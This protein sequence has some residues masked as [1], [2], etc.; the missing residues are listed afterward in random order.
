MPLIIRALVPRA[1]GLA[2]SAIDLHA[3]DPHTCLEASLLL[4][5]AELRG[6]SGFSGVPAG[7][8]PELAKHLVRRV[9]AAVGVRRDGPRFVLYLLG[10]EGR[11]RD[12]EGRRAR[13]RARRK[14]VGGWWVGG[15]VGGWVWVAGL[16]GGG[17]GEGLVCV[18]TCV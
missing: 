2:A 8:M 11:R 18:C 6:L 5:A 10:H 15:W 16:E 17:A 1:P 3:Y 9:A 12:N 7:E 13:A 4:R 14:Q